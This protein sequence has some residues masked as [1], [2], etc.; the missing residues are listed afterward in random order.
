ML[1]LRTDDYVECI[2][3][4]PILANSTIMPETDRLYT[5]ESVRLING[6]YSVRLNELDP[7]CHKGGACGCGNCGWDSRRFRRVYRPDPR[8][9][10]PFTQ[11]LKEAE[12]ALVDD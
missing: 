7:T 8:H 3:N 5:V 6:G 10:E 1:D 9:L 12:K 11:M 2:D 4:R